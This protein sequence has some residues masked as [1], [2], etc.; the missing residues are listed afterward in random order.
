MLRGQDVPGEIVSEGLGV[1]SELVRALMCEAAVLCQLVP[2]VLPPLLP[3]LSHLEPGG[4][5]LLV[6]DGTRQ[7]R[8]LP[9]LLLVGVHD[10]RRESFLSEIL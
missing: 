9:H 4:L 10:E 7:E 2:L 5:E 6:V 8:L 1:L 3:R